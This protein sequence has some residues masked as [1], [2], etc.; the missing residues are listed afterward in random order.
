VGQ[1]VP[2]DFRNEHLS[3]ADKAGAGLN[4]LYEMDF[5]EFFFMEET[6]LAD[7][8]GVGFDLLE[9]RLYQRLRSRGIEVT[10]VHEVERCL[11]P[12]NLPMPSFEQ[13]LVGFGSAAS[14][15]HPATGYSVGSQLR[16]AGD[17][18]GAIAAALQVEGV[19]PRSIALAGWNG[20]W[21]KDR[22]RKYICIGWGWRS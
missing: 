4:F 5:G 10:E 17:L 3:A 21:P 19:G 7:G 13:S 6:L 20:L 9:Q 12:M 18:A 14:M 2:R 16:R 15:V 22:L 1:F 11:F 8:P